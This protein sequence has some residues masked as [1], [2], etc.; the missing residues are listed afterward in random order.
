MTDGLPGGVAPLGLR[1]RRRHKHYN[2]HT[3]VISSL[4]LRNRHL[5]L[6]FVFFHPLRSRLTSLVSVGLHNCRAFGPE[7]DCS[8]G[9]FQIAPRNQAGGAPRIGEGHTL[10][11]IIE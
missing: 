4:L 1:L 2:F 8:E 3:H 9:S 5:G 6:Y 11:M 10:P 7:P